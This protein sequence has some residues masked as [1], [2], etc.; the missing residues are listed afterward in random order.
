MSNL[1]RIRQGKFTIYN[2]YTIDDIKNG[3]YKFLDI[4]DVLDYDVVLLTK[5]NEKDILN[6]KYIDNIYNKDFVLFKNSTNK[7]L[8]KSCNNNK[9]KPFIFY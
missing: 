3:N 8:Y 4:E 6:G 7:V 1:E 9:M 5:E 2:S